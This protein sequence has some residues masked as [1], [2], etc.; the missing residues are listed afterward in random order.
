MVL[1]ST[2][3]S[4]IYRLLSI[5]FLGVAVLTLFIALYDLGRLLQQQA[6]LFFSYAVLGF[7]CSAGLW[8]YKKWIVPLFALNAL[9]II[10]LKSFWLSQGAGNW[11]NIS[12][13]V[14]IAAAFAAGSYATRRTLR[15]EFIEPSVLTAF[16]FCWILIIE[17]SAI[18]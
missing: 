10:F 4:F 16:V 1:M 12:L 7:L 11:T 18:L 3:T 17:N 15:G 2:V 13:S 5:V 9:G 8:G 14:L 6:M